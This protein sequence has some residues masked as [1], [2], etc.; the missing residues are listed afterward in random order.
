MERIARVVLV[1]VARHGV[2]SPLLF[3]PGLDC[4]A[5]R[6][7][8]GARGKSSRREAEATTERQHIEEMPILLTPSQNTCR[9]ARKGP[10]PRALRHQRRGPPAPLDRAHSNTRTDIPRHTCTVTEIHRR[11]HRAPGDAWREPVPGPTGPR[12]VGTV[13]PASF[14]RYAP[15]AGWLCTGCRV[16]S[17]V[18]P[19]FRSLCP[20]GR[21]PSPRG[22]HP[23]PRQEPIDCTE[24][25][26]RWDSWWEGSVKGIS[27]RPVPTRDSEPL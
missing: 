5:P 4:P 8:A 24:G 12:S 11:A 1:L 23:S 26:P 3:S 21:H 17:C 13:R 2:C 22:R 16:H 19:P 20:R 27:N 25:A 10:L 18:S 7:D 6:I 14:P 9:C 15:A